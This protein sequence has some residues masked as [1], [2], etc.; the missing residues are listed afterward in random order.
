MQLKK[1]K[2]AVKTSCGYCL[3]W[4]EVPNSLRSKELRYCISVKKEVLS[5]SLACKDFIMNKIFWCVRDNCWR[6][7]TACHN[8]V[9]KKLGYNKEKCTEDCRQYKKV[10]EALTFEKSTN[11]NGLLR[12]RSETTA[13]MDEIDLIEEPDQILKRRTHDVSDSQGDD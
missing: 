7:L 3:K 10:Q 4:Y 2:E 13:S 5:S 12:R 8:R 6:D 11:G 1:P 9:V